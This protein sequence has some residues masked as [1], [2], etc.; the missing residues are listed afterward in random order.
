MT[1]FNNCHSGGCDIILPSLNERPWARG[2]VRA[3]SIV[4]S[5]FAKGISSLLLKKNNKNQF[6]KYQN[7][8][9]N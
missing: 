6:K 2:R 1:L 5:Q 7:L 3:P 8:K 4:F 9:Y